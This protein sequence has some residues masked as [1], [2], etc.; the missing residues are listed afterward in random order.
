MKT[1][2][3]TPFE[4]SSLNPPPSPGSL[5]KVGGWINFFQNLFI[6]VSVVSLFTFVYW[7]MNSRESQVVSSQAIGQFMRMSGPGGLQNQVVIETDQGSYPIIDAPAISKG[8]HLV[9]EQRVSGQRYV[10]DM[11]H[12]LCI[13][14]TANE[15]K[16]LGPAPTSTQTALPSQGTAP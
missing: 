6:L 15:F 8:T 1:T 3:P 12:S 11:P 2:N 9:L 14:T 4:Y 5:Q 16:R 10:C 7:V 13:K